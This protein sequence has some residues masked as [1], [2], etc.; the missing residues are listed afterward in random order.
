VARELRRRIVEWDLRAG[1]S[2]PPE[3]FLADEYGLSRSIVQQAYRALVEAG[4]VDFGPR[5]GY[6]VA[7]AVQMEYVQV[8]SGTRITAP[9]VQPDINPDMPWWLVI[10]FKVEAPGKEP[11]WYDAT[12]TML[13]VP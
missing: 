1:S 2:L 10:A 9:A 7:E 11:V 3:E 13:I 8:S 6:G 4:Q 12:R 5:G